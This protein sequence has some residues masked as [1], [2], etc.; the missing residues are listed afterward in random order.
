T[1]AERADVLVT[2]ALLDDGRQM[3]IA[4]PVDRAGQTVRPAFE[5]AAL[6]AS[7]TTEVILEH[8]RVSAADLLA[9]PS[10]D[11]SAQPGAVGTAGL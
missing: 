11:L 6:Q 8:V 2:G 5:L 1:A 9:G 4:L 3:L 10:A 7:C